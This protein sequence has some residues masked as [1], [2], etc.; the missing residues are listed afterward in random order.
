MLL[1]PEQITLIRAGI[2]KAVEENKS[3][4][5]LRETIVLSCHMYL[6]TLKTTLGIDIGSG[7]DDSSIETYLTARTALQELVG[8][9]GITVDVETMKNK[10]PEVANDTDKVP[11]NDNEKRD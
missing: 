6:E 3:A 4:I 7:K 9:F 8:I 5:S 11:S 2:S 10:E 1:S